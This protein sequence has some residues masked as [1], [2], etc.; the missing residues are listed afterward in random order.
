MQLAEL[1]D[2]E[3]LPQLAVYEGEFAAQDLEKNIMP[4]LN[5]AETA[6]WRTAMDKAETEG[7][8]FCT[9]PFHCAIGTKR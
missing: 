9:Y 5:S 6:A 4:L 3:K 1:T 7:T 2:V 8:F